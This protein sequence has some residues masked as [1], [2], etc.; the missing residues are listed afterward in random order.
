[1][2]G[3]RGAVA[4]L[5]SGSNP[6]TPSEDLWKGRRVLITGHTGFKGS[7]L[8][9]WLHM[10]GSDVH[11][12][13]VEPP[14]RP[15]LF[16]KA[17]VAR[18]L[19]SDH[20]SDVR[21]A[22]AVASAVSSTAPSVIFHLAAQPLVRDGY[23]RPTETFA[24]NVMG[25]VNVLEAARGTPSVEAIVV[26]TTD[27]VYRPPHLKARSGVEVET[28]PH[29]EDEELGAEDP[30]GW[31]KVAAEHAVAAFRGL[32]TIDDTPA[33]VIP[34]ATARAGNVL[35]GGDWSPERLVP[36]CIRSFGAGKPVE[37]RF[38]DAVRPWQHVL[39]PLNGY[40]LLAEALLE[41]D[42]AGLPCSLNFGP[43]TAS[44]LTVG[45]V[46]RRLAS[47]WGSGA[48]IRDFVQPD[49]PHENP[50]LRLDSALAQRTLGWVPIWDLDK[51]LTQTV[52]WYRTVAGGADARAVTQ[53][54]ISE[55]VRAGR[56]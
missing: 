25:T 30:Y 19:S 18:I 38:P 33:W 52:D 4:A 22:V 11:G 20:R 46:A 3:R 23:R 43:D 45:E 26:I 15:S 31:S 8:A 37:L 16:A 56:A 14:T 9:L 12:L 42:A 36:D 5:V 49:V 47:L 48:E 29:R 40:L 17:C 41:P 39:D 13:A 32:P 6:P 34:I 1:M 21:D 51:T 44:E 55:F 53:T 7:W 50:M 24:T 54:Q 10:L 28:A 27:K 35:G 2:A